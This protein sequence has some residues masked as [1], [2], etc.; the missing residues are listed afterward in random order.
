MIE[1]ERLNLREVTMDDF[2]S[3][4]KI[5][6]DTETMSFWPKPFNYEGVKSWIERNI[7]I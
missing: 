2:D 3:L 6:S 7:I 5:F 1:T 4:Y